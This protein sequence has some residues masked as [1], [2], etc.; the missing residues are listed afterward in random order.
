V[1]ARRARFRR[2]RVTDD[3]ETCPDCSDRDAVSFTFGHI[4][5]RA[6]DAPAVVGGA[7][8]V[9]S[10]ARSERGQSRTRGCETCGGLGKIRVKRDTAIPAVN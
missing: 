10:F 8:P 7:E 9:L 6:L 1:K 4:L 3:W 5:S 2:F